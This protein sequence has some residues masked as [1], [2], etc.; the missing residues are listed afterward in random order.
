MAER[1]AY[2]EAVV[3]ADITNFRKG[4]RDVRNEVGILSDTIGGVGRMARTLTFAVSAPLGALGTFAVQQAAGFEAAM[5]NINSIAFLSA[6]AFD[7]LSVKVREF[8]KN[9]RGGVTSAAES[10]Y[11]VFSAG[12]TDATLAFDVMDV[13]VRTAEAG[14]SDMNITTEALVATML[15][16]GMTTK[17]EAWRA[18]NALTA[19]V[20]VGVGSMEAFAGAVGNVLPTAAALNVSIEDVYGSMA[21]LTQ[22]GLSAAKASTAL[23]SAL[24]NLTKPTESM[25][26]AFHTLGVTSAE[27]LLQ[28]FGGL[29]G[30]MEALISTT[31]GTQQGLMKLFTNIRGARAVNLFARDLEGWQSAMDEF[32]QSLDG[33]TMRSW[34][35]QMQS[36]AAQWDLM[37]SA[38]QNLAVVIGNHL[39][40]IITPIVQS[41]TDFFNRVSDANPAIIELGVAFAA[42]VTAAAPLTWLITTMLNPLGVVIGAVA[43]LGTAFATNFMGISD[44]VSSVVNDIFGDLT[45]LGDAIKDVLGILAPDEIERYVP[46]AT[47][48]A[49]DLITI[50]EGDSLWSIWAENY[51]EDYTWD[52][53]KQAVGW[54]DTVETIHPGDVLEFANGEL[55]EVIDLSDVPEQLRGLFENN[56]K[57]QLTWEKVLEPPK[58]TDLGSRIKEAAATL[59]EKLKIELGNVLS[60]AADWLNSK[61]GEGLDW[62]TN[63]FTPQGG[64]GNTPL[65][66]AIEDLLSGNILGAINRIIPNLGTELQKV[67][68]DDWGTKIRE[69]FPDIISGLSNFFQQFVDWV[70]NDGLPTLA[71]TFGLIFGKLGK[72]ISDSIVSIWDWLSA[73]GDTVSNAVGNLVD[74]TIKPFFEELFS[75]LHLDQIFADLGP[76]I[77]AAISSAWEWIKGALSQLWEAVSGWVDNTIGAGLDWLAML[78]VPI[79]GGGNTPLYQALRRLLEGDLGAAIEAVLPDLGQTLSDGIG[80]NWGAKISEAFPRII[81]GLQEFFNNFGAWVI[82]D[83]L[84]TLA[85]SFGYVLGRIGAIITEGLLNLWDWITSSGGDI[86][87]SVSSSLSGSLQSLGEATISP[88]AEGLQEGLVVNSGLGDRLASTFENLWATIRESLENILTEIAGWADEHIGAGLEAIASLF[89]VSSEGGKSPVFNAVKDLLSG[90]ITGAIT[91]I[92]PATGDTLQ[93]GIGADWGTKIKNA[94]PRIVSGLETLFARFADWLINEGL[95][96]LTRSFGY[97]MGRVGVAVAQGLSDLWGWFTGSNT[98]EGEAQQS[99]A[100]IA[101]QAIID[102]F[103]EGLQEGLAEG[104]LSEDASI[105]DNLFAGLSG[106]L[107]LYAATWV[108]APGF[109]RN[110]KTVILTAIRGITFTSKSFV[111][112]AGAVFSGIRGAWTTIN[113]RTFKNGNPMKPTKTKGLA[114]AIKYMITGAVKVITFP[115]KLFSPLKDKVVAGISAAFGFIRSGASWALNAA[116]SI[117]GAITG[118]LSSVVVTAGGWAVGLLSSIGGAIAGAASAIVSTGAAWVGTI[119]SAIVGAITTAL[120][121][122]VTV[123]T[124][125]GIVLGSIGYML[126]PD[127]LKKGLSNALASL[128][129]G[130]FGEETTQHIQRSFEDSVY[131]A[132]AGV[133]DVLGKSDLGDTLRSYVSTYS[134]PENDAYNLGTDLGENVTRGFEDQIA[135]FDVA[136]LIENHI[137][138][139]G[140]PLA[141]QFNMIEDLPEPAIRGALG[142]NEEANQIGREVA[143]AG[144]EGMMYVMA[145]GIGSEADSATVINGYILP[146]AQALV[147]NF[148]LESDAYTSFVNFRLM[149]VEQSALIGTTLSLLTVTTAGLLQGF[150]N[151]VHQKM[152]AVTDVFVKARREVTKL[153]NAILSLASLDMNLNVNVNV[154]GSAS[155]D[156]SFASGLDYVPYDGFVAELHKGEMVVPADIASSYRSIPGASIVNGLG[157]NSST[158][159]QNVSITVPGIT[160]AD[161]LLKELK[162]RGVNLEQ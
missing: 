72:F 161:E 14:L 80:I 43:A 13:S 51:N 7:E 42:V 15:S 110:I 24:T 27:E 88:F 83:G 40:P 126:I 132:L 141:D 17:E 102:P 148:G 66:K 11:T 142:T 121:S 128:I 64:L 20:Q 33:A 70:V 28:E 122:V 108:I 91:D 151:T 112:L 149:I 85:K 147:D 34:E 82:N 95:P 26:D 98:V 107:T 115:A 111:S 101:Q 144:L 39:L 58:A 106:A 157:D 46:Q 158:T 81:N 37:T 19:M 94:F 71:R 124:L 10:L 69:A 117:V 36:F 127:E 79:G 93:E 48:R 125:G 87:S 65:F 49:T 29:T 100:N 75:N 56:P 3:G 159:Y 31:D 9:T 61:V 78:F 145:E 119:A 60:H 67:I 129:D 68:G 160:N 35:Q 154:S 77:S 116:S 5:R 105:F 138:S 55:G 2:L 114:T 62:L 139:L 84:P 59:W 156:G 41:F 12:I 90:D 103:K 143:E 89:T 1:L 21:F 50:N 140:E 113:P 134:P 153:S 131:N 23:N 73:A 57:Y 150:Y 74:N 6:E 137:T 54:G 4:M 133:A 118:A 136:T 76:R 18:S 44:T 53:F 120:T 63:L 86:V 52:D 47:L 123:V 45:G 109:A 146:V 162:R 152:N 8:G 104:G 30:A 16:Y 99:G 22:R 130:I 97:V 135:A 92:L 96:T 38:L 25:I 32:N 155:V